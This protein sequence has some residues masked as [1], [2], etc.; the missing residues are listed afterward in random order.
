MRAVLAL[1][2]LTLPAS[3]EEAEA[4]FRMLDDEVRIT[5]PDRADHLAEPFMVLVYSNAASRRST[6][7]VH[8]IETRFG[9][10]SFSVSVNSS[11]PETFTVL[12]WPQEMWPVPAEVV[13]KDG[14]EAAIE[15][16]P[17]MM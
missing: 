3:A 15:F 6:G 10:V 11:G 14:E 9:P 13:V 17:P 5:Y 2:A 4:P 12:D 8:T 16:L 1:L 7:G